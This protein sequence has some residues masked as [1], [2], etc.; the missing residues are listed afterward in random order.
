[1]GLSLAYFIVLLLGG[2][3]SPYW[4]HTGMF[5]DCTVT[6]GGGIQMSIYECSTGNEEDCTGEYPGRES[7]CSTN[8]CRM[9][10]SI[11]NNNYLHCGKFR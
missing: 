5:T 4:S 8:S 11:L 6:C 7:T 10:Y 3:S 1:M 2:I 9:Y